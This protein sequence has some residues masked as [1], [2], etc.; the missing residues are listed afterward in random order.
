[1]AVLGLG[2]LIL[3]GQGCDAAWSINTKKGMAEMQLC[4]LILPRNGCETSSNNIY[5]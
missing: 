3:I 1:M 2:V 5:S 4:V